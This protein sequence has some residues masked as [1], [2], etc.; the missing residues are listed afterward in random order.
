MRL[1]SEL[2]GDGLALE[3]HGGLRVEVAGV[4]PGSE[5]GGS[6]N[7]GGEDQSGQQEDAG[8]EHLDQ[9][10]RAKLAAGEDVV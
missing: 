10:G 2:S 8:D 4:V 7:S 5:W 6:G 9:Q 1:H 3:R